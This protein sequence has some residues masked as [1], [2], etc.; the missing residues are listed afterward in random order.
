MQLFFSRGAKI[1]GLKL[2]IFASR[3]INLVAEDNAIE[4][5][6]YHLH[7]ALNAGRIDL[8]RFL[9]VSSARLL[10][11]FDRSV[12][13]PVT[14]HKPAPT[15]MPKSPTSQSP[16]E[17]SHTNHPIPLSPNSQFKVFTISPPQLFFSY[18]ASPRLFY[19]SDYVLFLT[20]FC[21]GVYCEIVCTKDH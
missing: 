21:L 14:C 20:S 19:D 10:L 18:S 2:F 3:L 6:I 1:Y 17:R 16:R 13:P 4:D 11:C 15:S 7:R 5:T 8:E 9:S 12:I